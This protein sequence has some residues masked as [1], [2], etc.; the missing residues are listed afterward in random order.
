MKR[1]KLTILFAM[2][3]TAAL[4]LACENLERGESVTVNADD[5][6]DHGKEYEHNDSAQNQNI[7]AAY[8]LLDQ[9]IFGNLSMDWYT[10]SLKDEIYEHADEVKGDFEAIPYE[11][12]FFPPELISMAEEGLYYTNLTVNK[13]F[14]ASWDDETLDYLG[15]DEFRL[16]LDE[17]Y[18]LFPELNQYK[19]EI[20]TEYDAYNQVIESA[21]CSG[22]YHLDT[23]PDED[24][25]VFV[26][27]DGGHD[28]VNNV[29]LA[30][31]TG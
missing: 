4:L 10:D 14:G 8:N 15:A 11:G 3:M 6:I 31:R 18:Q 27:S 28:Q 30:K 7:S 19:D 22:I 2:I 29:R 24:Y 9:D 23:A 5:S 12:D 20:E 17:M 1:K 21:G 16:N 26:Y 25:Y 13:N